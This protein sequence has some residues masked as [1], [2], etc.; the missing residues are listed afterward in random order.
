MPSNRQHRAYRSP[1]VFSRQ[2]LTTLSLSGHPVSPPL[3]LF[4][5]PEITVTDIWLRR[6]TETLD[7][8]SVV[9]LSD[10][11]HSLF[12]PL[13]QIQRVV[14]LANRQQPDLVALT[15]DY[16]TASANYIWPVAEQLGQLRTRLGV[17][18][19]LG[20]HDFAVDAEE[21]T[22]ALE[23]HGI[24]VLRNSR[25]RLH[26]RGAPLWVLGVDDLWYNADDLSAAV[27]GVPS[28]DIK[29]LLCHNPLG[30]HQAA[31]YG[32]DLVLA[33]HTHGG[34]VKL[35]LLG[36]VYGRSKLGTRFVDGWNRLESTQIYVS[37]GIGKVVLPVRVGCRPEIACLRLRKPHA[38]PGS[39]SSKA[40]SRWDSA[41]RQ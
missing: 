3:R 24:R 6:L 20:N 37:R 15:G 17:F 5:D 8:L 2:G 35:P 10:I 27:T 39:A 4:R 28:R 32:I 13:R 1:L 31:A 30:I 11:H 34:Q 12:T 29:L 26:A 23:T 21:I 22:R 16:V 36:S 41:A 38:M 7:N 14:Q 25:A 33:G 40:A 19:V 18:A 9:H